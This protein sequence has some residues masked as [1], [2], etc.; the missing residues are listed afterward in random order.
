MTIKY[1]K[2]F[3][4]CFSALI[5]VQCQ[6]DSGKSAFVLKNSSNIDLK[7]KAI[8]I[9]R[10]Q[11]TKIPDGNL[12]PLIITSAGDTLPAQLDD[13]DGDKKW[14]ELFFVVDIPANKELNYTVEW[15]NDPPNFPART[16][17]RFGKRLAADIRVKPALD[18]E[19][20][21]KDL[22]LVM[23]FQRYQTDGPTWEND[24]VGFR[25]Y[26]D[27]RNSKD[28]FGKKTPEISPEDV[29]IN[30]KGETEDN[31][32]VM[33]DWG[34]DILSVGNSVGVGGFGIKA[35][36]QLIRLGSIEGDTMSNVE[37]TNFKIVTEGPV[38]TALNYQYTNWKSEDRTYAVEE[39]TTIWPGMYGYQNTVQL[40][41][42]EGDEELVVGL[43][44]SNTEMALESYEENDKY[45]VLYTHDQ[46][47][48]DKTW[49]L[50][51]AIILP[52]DIYLGNMEAPKTGRL[53]N[54]F[55]ARLKVENNKPLTY[56]A[57]ACWELSDEGFTDKAYFE[58]YLKNL[59]NQLAAEV[60]VKVK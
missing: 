14:D 22:P 56:Y 51:L 10:Q 47:T 59:T 12:F 19:L 45:V 36:D 60:Q 13:M 57:V 7:D 55:L 53:S 3:L 11:L 50:G 31:Y 41:G 38:R 8:S 2:P 4:L 25:H 6:T 32:H 40:S 21:A 44:N 48:Y 9:A 15:V 28:V 35:G 49:W 23:G 30:D 20:T 26:L 46:Q 17:V 5:L 1:L 27:G 54:T 24:K 34:R 33:E 43:V 16:S 42:L 39:N 52:R 37:K 29:G 18:E 58:K